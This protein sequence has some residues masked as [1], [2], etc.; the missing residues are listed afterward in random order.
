M[1]TDPETG[2]FINADD[3]SY[4][5]PETIHGLNLYAY[6]Q[7]NP[8]MHVDPSGHFL[9]LAITIWS[10]TKLFHNEI[11]A[12]FDE[13]GAPT[14]TSIKNQDDPLN[15]FYNIDWS[16]LAPWQKVIGG[17]GLVTI[18]VG[19]IALVAGTI[20]MFIPPVSAIGV[21]VAAYGAVLMIIGAHIATVLGVD[22]GVWN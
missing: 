7:N 11:I 22:P 2:R 15:D 9:L 5:Q 13:Q 19:A 4:L 20:T 6:C 10:I 17:I 21:K 8:I 14:D 12:L 3:V 16:Q 18:G 1:T